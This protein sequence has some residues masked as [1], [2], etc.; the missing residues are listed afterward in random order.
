[1]VN[2]HTGGLDEAFKTPPHLVGPDPHRRVAL[3][4]KGF[5]IYRT[6]AGFFELAYS[7]SA[8]STLVVKRFRSSTL[9][10]CWVDEGKR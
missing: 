7:R 1:M 5:T 6:G 9:A 4:Y 3:Q 2:E 8:D 10:V